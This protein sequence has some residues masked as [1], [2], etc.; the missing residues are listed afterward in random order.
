M[1]SQLRADRRTKRRPG[2]TTVDTTTTSLHHNVAKDQEEATTVDD[3]NEGSTTAYQWSAVKTEVND[4]SEHRPIK[5]TT[6]SEN[7]TSEDT[8]LPHESSDQTRT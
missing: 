5:D 7:I 6:R 2:P 3:T 8:K 4:M 1:G